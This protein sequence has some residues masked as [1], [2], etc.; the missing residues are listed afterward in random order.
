M[1]QHARTPVTRLDTLVADLAQ[2]QTVQCVALRGYGEQH[3]PLTV[4]SDHNDSTQALVLRAPNGGAT[5]Q[6][7]KALRHEAASVHV[8]T[9]HERHEVTGAYVVSAK[10][11]DWTSSVLTMVADRVRL[12]SSTS[13]FDVHSFSTHKNGLA[14]RCPKGGVCVSS[15]AGGVQHTTTGNVDIQLESDHTSVNVATRGHKAHTIR[16]GNANTDTVVE[17]QLTVKGK[18]VLADEAVV[19]KRVSVVHELQNV[20]EL[21]GR[22]APDGAFDFALVGSTPTTKQIS[23]QPTP[24]QPPHKRGLVYDHVRDLFYF[25]SELGSYQ[26]HRF[27]LPKAYADVQA[28]AYVAQHR[29]QAPFV[30]AHAVQCRTVKC[31]GRDTVLTLQA[32][33]VQCTQQLACASVQ[34][35]LHKSV[36]L[37]TTS[38]RTDTL[39][40]K[41]TTHTGTLHVAHGLT[42]GTGFHADKWFF[43]TVGAHGMHRTLQDYIDAS[44]D[45]RNSAADTTTN[46]ATP[47]HT[48]VVTDHAVM[49]ATSVPHSCNAVVN[50]RRLLVDGRHGVLTGVL[51]ITDECEAFTL[52]DA[53]AAQLTLTTCSEYT[54]ER[55]RP[56]V[57]TLRNVHG[58][59]KDWQFDLPDG[60]LRLEHCTL[61]FANQVLGTLKAVEVVHSVVRGAPWRGLAVVG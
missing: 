9:D 2:L 46:P 20:V 61:D 4:Q 29:V 5:V 24:Q 34:T 18:L 1:L 19:E 8:K 53:R 22:S 45:V 6:V 54:R 57:Y 59:A 37:D 41:D 15:G 16:L 27:A 42:V 10:Q 32:P 3:T 36:Q 40:V 26:H 38:A 52:V 39:H 43:N 17:N 35:E 23:K 14:L 56:C 30:D 55:K 47:Q 48:P 28:R 11:T 50:Q 58:T 21:G 33:R 25:A 13:P 7:A 60:T 44:D 12:Q 49:Q 31:T 51:E